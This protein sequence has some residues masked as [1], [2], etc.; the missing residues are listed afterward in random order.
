MAESGGISGVGVAAVFAG[1]LL[2]WSGI[3]GYRVSALT[4]D[5][6]SGQNPSALKSELPVTVGGLFSGLLP[7]NSGGTG[8]GS[9]G[10]PG[11]NAVTPTGG[12][13]PQSN[14]ANKALGQRMAGSFG[15]SSGAEW[16]ALNNIVMAESGWS[17]TIANPT[18]NAR[19][20]AQNINGW[21]PGYQYGNAPQQIAWLLHYIK[22]RYGDPI[23]AWQFHLAHG[24]Y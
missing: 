16:I 15:W 20:I 6:I 13:V 17:S 8:P 12:Q 24:W 14:A 23:T 2:V 4:R 10:K 21:G 7:W 18:S 11:S 3:K 9:G 1:G 22:T 5:I 19:G